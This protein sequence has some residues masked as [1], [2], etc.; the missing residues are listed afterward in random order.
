MKYSDHL[1]A[2][3]STKKAIVGKIEQDRKSIR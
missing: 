1:K 3:A 2:N